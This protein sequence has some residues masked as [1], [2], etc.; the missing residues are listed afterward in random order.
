MIIKETLN[1]LVLS[2]VGSTHTNLWWNSPN[3]AFGGKTPNEQFDFDPQVVN[4][5]LLWFCSPSGS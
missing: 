1:Q 5:Y 4:D 3:K 2:L